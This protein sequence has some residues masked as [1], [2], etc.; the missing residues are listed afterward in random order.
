MFSHGSRNWGSTIQDTVLPEA[1]GSKNVA[2]M[3]HS[4][5]LAYLS[6]T[7]SAA[8]AGH[9]SKRLRNQCE[10]TPEVFFSF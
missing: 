4:Q 2:T 3:C 7:S 6:T 1:S 10:L 9:Q 5:T 8:S